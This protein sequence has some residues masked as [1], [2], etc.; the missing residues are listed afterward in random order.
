MVYYKLLLTEEGIE[1]YFSQYLIL[2]IT[3][4]FHPNL[5]TLFKE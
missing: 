4:T 3:A 5:I 2:K 1:A